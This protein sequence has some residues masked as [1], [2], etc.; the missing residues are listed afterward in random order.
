VV[1]QE[2]AEIASDDVEERV[3]QSEQTTTLTDGTRTTA[4]SLLDG[5]FEIALPTEVA[6]TPSQ[7][8]S[9]SENLRAYY[10]SYALEVQQCRLTFAMRSHGLLRPRDLPLGEGESR[11]YAPSE[12]AS[13]RLEIVT[14]HSRAFDVLGLMYAAIGAVAFEADGTATDFFLWPELAQGEESVVPEGDDWESDDWYAAQR[15][16]PRL[17]RC[18]GVAETLLSEAL[19][20]LVARRPFAP[21]QRRLYFGYDEDMDESIA[22]EG[23]IPD[24]WIITTEPAYDAS[25]DDLHRRQVWSWAPPVPS[26]RARVWMYA[27]LWPDDMPRPSMGPR[28][29]H[30]FDHDLRFDRGQGEDGSC[31]WAENRDLGLTHTVCLRGTRAEQNELAA[32]LRTFTRVRSGDAALAAPARQTCV[33]HIRDAD[34]QTNVRALASSRSEVVGTIANGTAI[35]PSEQRG[36]WLRITTPHVGWVFRDNVERHCE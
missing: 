28:R 23:A 36:P 24:G 30:L 20:T 9:S 35:V 15:Q 19:P 12:G 1:E 27:G 31:A 33:T 11:S 13:P 16:D 8:W 18:Y 25:F 14:T 2:D 3:A 26:P 17:A 6:L 10:D 32:I 22:Y 34:G 29:E 7:A 5:R 4:R 21:V